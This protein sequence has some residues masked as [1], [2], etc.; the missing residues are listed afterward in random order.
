MNSKDVMVR[1]V[2][3]A[4]AFVGAGALT[5][6]WDFYLDVFPVLIVTGLM[7]TLVNK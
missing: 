4:S 7:A 6:A 5:N 2:I 3:V 1:G